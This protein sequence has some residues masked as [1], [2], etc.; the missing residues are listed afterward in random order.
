MPH[1]RLA[2]T[3]LLLLATAAGVVAWNSSHARPGRLADSMLDALHAELGSSKV[4]S[5]MH[6]VQATIVDGTAVADHCTRAPDRCTY[7]ATMAYR[8]AAVGD[9]PATFVMLEASTEVDRST[10]A[11]PIPGPWR[12]QVIMAGV[13][14]QRSVN[15]ATGIYANLASTPLARGTNASLVL[16]KAMEAGIEKALAQRG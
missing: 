6:G 14:E 12:W 16:L 4:S 1:V 5:A 9:E 10:G 7:K 11:P 13:D 15:V 8:M 2:L 3:A